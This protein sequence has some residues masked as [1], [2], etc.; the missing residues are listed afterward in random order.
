MLVY[1]ATALLSP[2][3]SQALSSGNCTGSDVM[4]SRAADAGDG[5]YGDLEAIMR[6]SG[7]DAP[8][9]LDEYDVERMSAFLDTPLEINLAAR[10]R[11]VSSGLFTQYQVASLLDYRERHGDVLSLN[12]LAAVDGFSQE[13]AEALAPFVSLFSDA[14]PGK[15]SEKG[16]DV[17]NSLYLRSNVRDVAGSPEY[18]YGMKY[19]FGL[20]GRLE[21]GITANRTYGS[22]TG[23]PDGG[24]FHIIYYGRRRLGKIVVGDYNLRYGQGLALWN[25]FRMNS[26][27]SPESFYLRPSGISPY[28]S[29]SGTDSRRGLAVDFNIG[30]IAISS[31]VAV[32]GLRE[33][34]A[35]EKPSC[36]SLLPAVNVAWYGSNAQVSLTGYAET[37][38]FRLPES[39]NGNTDRWI[40]APV[41]DAGCSVDFRWCV[42]GVDLFG[43][44]ALD[45]IGLEPAAVM[46][47]V[48]NAGESLTLAGRAGYSTDRYSAAAG[49]RFLAGDRVRLK[50][51][52]GF[53]SSVSRHSGTFSI[54]AAYYPEPEYG[55]SGP[56]MQIK[57]LLNHTVQVN[58][59]IA[60]TARISER[61]R[62]GT[63][64]NRTDLRMDVKYSSGEW[65]AAIRLNGLYNKSLGLLGY[66]ECG[67]KPD[68]MSVYFRA[69]MFRIDNWQDRI[70][71]YERDAPGNFNVPAYYGRGCWAALTAGFK[72][73][74]R[75]RAYFRVST[76]QYPWKSPTAS[77]RSPRNECRI[78]L[79]F[80]L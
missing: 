77:E 78:L 56:G 65:L 50:G 68:W 48:F 61:L 47:A 8:E 27:T 22:S 74:R 57:L 6:L 36:L 43:E 69:G 44:A 52:T 33:M 30:R 17:S 11:L 18:A 35:G 39:G 23:Y 1:A 40:D 20:N 80:S 25:G 64:K 76:L 5:K 31:S 71:A 29:Y 32:R 2:G 63:E 12:E 59:A 54:D 3:K 10:S 53:G 60:I 7:V 79:T 75:F 49:G 16:R 73:F 45:A 4:S 15:A 55:S 26:L 19:R 21:I 37:A 38:G 62:N 34:M 14:A 66:I 24:S 13:R 58:P 67:W 46:G 42:R 51:R 72:L 28:W 41:S 9:L 70:Y